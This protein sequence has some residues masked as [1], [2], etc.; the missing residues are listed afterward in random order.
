MTPEE[1]FYRAFLHQEFDVTELSLSSYMIATSKGAGHY[2]AIPVFPAR[3][4]RHS[5]IYIRTDRG[6]DQAK[7]LKDKT[8]GI[9]EYQM[10]AGL[11]IRGILQDEYGVTPSMMRW[12]TGG[13]EQPG[14]REK[15]PL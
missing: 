3:Q 15:I 12:R 8:V 5:S 4:F 6:I 2:A 1:A 10:T 11:W 9:P 14:R 7:D 13:L